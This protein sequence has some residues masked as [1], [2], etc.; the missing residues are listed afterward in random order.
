[1]ALPSSPVNQPENKEVVQ[2][3]LI[4][5]ERSHQENNDAKYPSLTTSQQHS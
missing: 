1:M 3:F 5:A 4:A 2:E